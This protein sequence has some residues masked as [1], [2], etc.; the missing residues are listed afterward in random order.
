MKRE[1]VFEA[2]LQRLLEE[3]GEDA[4]GRGE[5]FT[6]LHLLRFLLPGAA[7]RAAV[8]SAGPSPDVVM[9]AANR[10][11][12]V[13]VA[14]VELEARALEMVLTRAA[15]R[16]AASGGDRIAATDVI[17]ALAEEPACAGGAVLAAH[18]VAPLPLKLYVSHRPP[19]QDA[20]GVAR[21]LIR[22]LW[23]RR[24]AASPAPGPADRVQIVMHDDPFTTKEFV[25]EILERHFAAS[26]DEAEAVMEQIHGRGLGRLGE[27][28]HAEAV[29]R[30]DEIT[31]SARERGFPL[32]LSIEAAHAE[33]PRAELRRR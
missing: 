28:P 3:G 29:R 5:A 6:T 27:L 21:G 31:R 25:V 32:R 2:E 1:V 30:I 9:G 8:A 20:R 24:P 15:R 13:G 18:G 4:R 19:R 17:I 33:L 11:L 12:E 7:V 22:R 14:D 10:D 23:S 16:V 26:R